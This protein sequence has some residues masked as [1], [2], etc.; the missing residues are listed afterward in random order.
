[1][2]E[3]PVDSAPEAAKPT[4]ADLEARKTAFANASAKGGSAEEILANSK[5]FYAFLTGTDAS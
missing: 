5:A 3:Q 1:M 4:Q 2:S